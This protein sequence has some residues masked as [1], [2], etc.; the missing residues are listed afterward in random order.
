[1]YHNALDPTRGGEISIIDLF[2]TRY[3]FLNTIIICYVLYFIV[4]RF[5]FRYKHLIFVL[6]G[7]GLIPLLGCC[8]LRDTLIVEAEICFRWFFLFQIMLLGGWAASRRIKPSFVRDGGIMIGLLL[9]YYGYKALCQRAGIYWLQLLLPLLLIALV[10]FV[11][12]VLYAVS[13]R[14][15]FSAW[16]WRPVYAFSRLTLE[17]YI[18]QF[19]VIEFFSRYVFPF[20]FMSAIVCIICCAAM[21]HLI[22]GRIVNPLLVY[23]QRRLSSGVQ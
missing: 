20:G 15:D 10:Y 8:N 6:T 21:L 9:A 3:W 19:A 2:V 1:M 18:V 7:I 17:I 23:L 4:V 12:R 5:L 22:T 13:L 14:C 16:S 11:Y